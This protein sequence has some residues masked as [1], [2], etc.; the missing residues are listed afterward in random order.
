MLDREKILSTIMSFKISRL[1][2]EAY[3]NGLRD[4]M[5][6]QDIVDL[7]ADAK[8]AGLTNNQLDELIV[9]TARKAER[10]AAKQNHNSTVG[11]TAMRQWGRVS[12]TIRGH[13]GEAD[14]RTFIAP[15]RLE[16]VDATS[17]TLK[18]SPAIANQL[19]STELAD[20]IAELWAAETGNATAVKIMEQ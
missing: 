14:Y 15:I 6:R 16:A 7:L 18:T 4:F 1:N 10:E 12:Q 9:G 5:D 17:V 19:K 3:L 8:M 13:I 11:P 2:A 20:E